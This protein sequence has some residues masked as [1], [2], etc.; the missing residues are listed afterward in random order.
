M[1]IFPFGIISVPPMIW[2]PNQLV[3]APVGTD[4]V[5]D[6]NLESHP[7]SVTFWTREGGVMVLSN[8]KYD[9]VLMPSNLYKVQMRLRIK[10]LKPEDF[11][12]YTCVAK[13]SHGETEGNIRLYG[14]N[15]MN[16][17]KLNGYHL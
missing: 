7:Q 3:G 10:D 5:L 17:K 8:E 14:K 1:N 6:C 2:I 15:T 12:S 13:N 11:G 16:M 4:V 9:S